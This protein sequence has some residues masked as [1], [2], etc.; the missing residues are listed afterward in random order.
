MRLWVIFFLSLFFLYFISG[1]Y[2]LILIIAMY[3]VLNCYSGDIFSL[4]VQL[5]LNSSWCSVRISSFLITTGYWQIVLCL[6]PPPPPAKDVKFI[7]LNL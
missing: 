5:S 2:L 4:S 6:P 1:T 3:L 7:V